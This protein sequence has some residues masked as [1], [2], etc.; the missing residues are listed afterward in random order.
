MTL[1]L[2][3]EPRWVEAHGLAADPT[4]WQRDGAV[5]NERAK[6]AVIIGRADPAALRRAYPDYTILTVTEPALPHARAILHT[7]PEPDALPDLDGA[8]LL[9]DAP[10][11]G[12]PVPLAAELAAAPRVWA[13]WVDGAPV[14]FAYAPWRSARLFDVSVDVMP[15]A[16]QL[17]LGTLVAAAMI[18]DERAGGREPVWGAD[19][20]NAASLRLAARLGFVPVD[21]LFVI[22]P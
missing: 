3:D 4:S 21:H 9:G 19:E 2:P 22:P 7:L 15:A 5:G 16:R 8:A 20:D 17:G 1:D 18:R 13:A 10:L 6:L 12:V 11:D 14:A